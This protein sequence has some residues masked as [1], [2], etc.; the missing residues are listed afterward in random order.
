MRPLSVD[1]SSSVVF[2]TLSSF[3][4]LLQGSTASTK[5]IDALKVYHS[6]N[7]SGMIKTAIGLTKMAEYFPRADITATQ[8]SNFAAEQTAIEMTQ[9]FFRLNLHFFFWRMSRQSARWSNGLFLLWSGYIMIQKIRTT[10]TKHL[11]R[12]LTTLE[13][14]IPPFFIVTTEVRVNRLAVE[15]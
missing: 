9:F 14:F 1:L 5:N 15:K 10:K 13:K 7:S 8:L 12:T 11:V 3:S 6:V 2:N 4:D